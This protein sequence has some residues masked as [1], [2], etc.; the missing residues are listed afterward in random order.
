MIDPWNRLELIFNISE[1]I[2]PEIEIT[3]ISESGMVWL[4]N[5][6]VHNLRS[7]NTEFRSFDSEFPVL[8][9]SVQDAV[10]A[11]SSGELLG[12]FGGELKVEQYTLPEMIYIFEE[13]GF[14]ILSYLTGPHWNAMKLITLMEWFRIVKLHEPRVSIKLSQRYFSTEWIRVFDNLLRAYCSEAPQ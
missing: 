14:V 1:E 12:V 11:V 3:N 9:E 4:V 13:P 6:V 7:M 5:Y 2:H 10:Q 8:V